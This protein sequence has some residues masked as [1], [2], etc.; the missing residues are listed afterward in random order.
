MRVKDI[1]SEFSAGLPWKAL[2]LGLSLKSYGE[3]AC[4]LLLHFQLYIK[5]IST[6]KE[7]KGFLGIPLHSRS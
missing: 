2:F 1:T 6:E 5:N 3:L 4:L 7:N